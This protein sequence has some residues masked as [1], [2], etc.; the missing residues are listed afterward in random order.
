LLFSILLSLLL[1]QHLADLAPADKADKL[2]VVVNTWAFTHATRALRPPCGSRISRADSCELLLS[3]VRD[4][5]L[6]AAPSAL[7]V[8]RMYGSPVYRCASR[9]CC[10]AWWPKC[11]PTNAPQRQSLISCMLAAQRRPGTPSQRRTAPAQPSTP[12]SRCCS[13]SYSAC[14]VFTDGALSNKL[15]LCLGIGDECPR[16]SNPPQRA[17]ERT[18]SM[19]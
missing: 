1:L 19:L 18:K 6:S 17:A 13:A 9:R 4:T 5:S 14:T 2:P 7:T 16:P 8:A 12:L 11:M 3:A 15:R 10:P